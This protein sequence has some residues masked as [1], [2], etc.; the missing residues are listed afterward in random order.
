VRQSRL[1]PDDDIRMQEATRLA[2]RY[3]YPPYPNPWVGCVIVNRGRVVGRG[4]HR[5]PGSPHAETEALQQAGNKARGATLY[6]TLEPC[7][8]FG[9]T[10]PCTDA[11]IQAGVA[12]VVYGL[13]DPNQAVA[14]RGARI[15]RSHG[16]DV[17]GGVRSK[18]CEA[19]NEAYLKFWRT[20]MPFVSFK[21]ATSL[22]GKIATRTG[23]SKWITDSTARRIARSMR[24][25]HQAV[26]VGI[27]TVLADNPHLG[28]RLA[29]APEPWRIVLDSHLRTPPASQ[30]VRS[31]RCIIATTRSAGRDRHRALERHGAKV[32]R[33]AGRRVPLPAL[34]RKLA[35]KEI[36]SVLVEGG[37]DVAGSFFDANLVDQVCWFISPMIIGSPKSLSAVEGRGAKRVEDAW[38]LRRLSLMPAGNSLLLCGSLRSDRS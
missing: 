12:R 34:L 33:F 25:Q 37:A 1:R 28:P 14:G 19:L 8:H 4:A 10:P 15:L 31:G 13:R 6:V 32:W 3:V 36:I 7:C 2:R 5:S 22:D 18:E 24:A 35:S 16:I 27:G 17:V 20:G 21:V 26:L 11:I 29:T 9:R 30:V 23:D 38:P